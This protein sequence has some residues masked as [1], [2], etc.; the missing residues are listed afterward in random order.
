MFAVH[1]LHL[2]AITLLVIA[3]FSISESAVAVTRLDEAPSVTVRYHDLNLNSPEGI[4]SLYGRIHAAAVDVCKPVEDSQIISRTYMSEWNECI[5][6]AVANAVRKIHN[7]KLNAYQWERIRGRWFRS[8]DTPIN[9]A[10][11]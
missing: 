3:T 4:A 2:R 8:V 1:Q 6:H 9:V 11:R 5:A 10:K 7:E